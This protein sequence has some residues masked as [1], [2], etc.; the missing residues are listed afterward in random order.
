MEAVDLL[1]ERGARL[2]T[3]A[4]DYGILLQAQRGV[5]MLR[6]EDTSLIMGQ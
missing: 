5:G 3:V 6:L 2:E 1:A 4:G